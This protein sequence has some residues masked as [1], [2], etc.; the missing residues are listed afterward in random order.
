MDCPATVEIM[1]VIASEDCVIQFAASAASATALVDATLKTD[2]MYIPADLVKIITPPIDKK[3]FS[4][5]GVVNPGT[6]VIQFLESWSG[7]STASQLPR[8]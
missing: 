5:I 3:S 6:A 1:E 8:R 2:A 4:I 7:L